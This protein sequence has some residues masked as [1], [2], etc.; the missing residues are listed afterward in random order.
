MHNRVG[1][2]WIYIPPLRL[3]Q[4]DSGPFGIVYGVDK[5]KRQVYCRI[6][7]TWSRPSGQAWRRIGTEKMK[8]VSAG[9]YGVWATNEYHR[10]YFRIGVTRTK[11]QGE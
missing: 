8:S 9:L 7:I 2:K 5:K 6:G 11:P 10:I 3:K 1:R 4:I